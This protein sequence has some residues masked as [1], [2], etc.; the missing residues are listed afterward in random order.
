MLVLIQGEQ[1]DHSFDAVA[2]GGSEPAGQRGPV[3]LSLVHRYRH[4]VGSAFRESLDAGPGEVRRARPPA[5]PR[6]GGR[7]WVG[8]PPRRAPDPANARA[9]ST[10]TP[11]AHTSAAE[12][13]SRPGPP[14]SRRSVPAAT[15]PGRVSATVCSIA[16]T[17]P[18]CG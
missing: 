5:H 15:A 4:D 18:G 16:V 8:G 10:G 6:A 13:S 3:E 2:T 12:A 7:P 1:G 11:R 9:Q 14:S 17:S